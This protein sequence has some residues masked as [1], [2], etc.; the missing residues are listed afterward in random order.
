MPSQGLISTDHKISN[1]SGNIGFTTIQTSPKP[2][3][4][5]KSPIEIMGNHRKMW[6]NIDIYSWLVVL[7]ILKNDG[8]CQWEG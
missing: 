8:V 3:S 2:G 7:T 4:Y 5:G 1:E 6:G